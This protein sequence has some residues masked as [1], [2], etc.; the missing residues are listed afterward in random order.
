MAKKKNVWLRRVLGVALAA[1]LVLQPMSTALGTLG[2]V[3]AAQLTE[4]VTSGDFSDSSI[5]EVRTEGASTVN[6]EENKIVF[7]IVDSGADWSN[8]LKYVPGIN[9]KQGQEYVISFTAKSSVSRTIQYGFDSG[10]SGITTTD[11]EAGV[12]TPISYTHTGE[13]NQDGHSYMFYLGAITDGTNPTEAHTVEISNFSVKT[14][15]DTT[16]GDGGGNEGGTEDPSVP[17]TSENLLTNGDFA[18]KQTGWNAFSNNATITW[19]EYS[20]VFE[21]NGYEADWAQSLYQT[22]T[23]EQGEKYKVSFD[24]ESSVPR[25][26]MSDIADRSPREFTS[27]VIPA[28]TKTTLSYETTAPAASS[29]FFIY[30]GGVSEAHTVTISNVSI[31]KATG[32][33]SGETGEGGSGDPGEGGGSGNTPQEPEVPEGADTQDGDPVPAVE[34]NL[35]Q[36]GNFE[37]KGENWDKNNANADVYFNKYRT[38]FQINGE[39]AD[40]GQGLFQFVTL[41]AGPKYKVSFDIETTVERTVTVDINDAGREFTSDVIPANQKTTISYETSDV[42]NGQNKFYIY[43][44]GVSGLGNHK[45]VI[46]NVSIVEC[47]VELPDTENDEAPAALT[48]LKGVNVDDAIALKDGKFTDG[49]NNWETWCVDWMQTW[50]V[51][52]Y[53][54]VENGMSV[55]ITNV[56]DGE[57]NVAWDAQLNQKIDLK[58]DLQYTISFDVHSEK[59]RAFNVVVN[60]LATGEF[61]KTIG[62]QKDETRHVVLNIP[63]QSEDALNKI[64]SIQMGKVTGEVRENTLTFTNMKIEVNGCEAL[65]ERVSDGKF[66]DGFGSFVPGTTAD[67]TIKADEKSVQADILSDTRAEDV[68]LTRGGIDLEAGVTYALS[69]MAGATSGN[70]VITVQLPDGTS[71]PF[72]LTDEATLYTTEFTPANDITAGEIVFLLGGAQDNVCLDTVYLN[73]KGYAEATGI[74]LEQHDIQALT[75]Y[76]APVISEDV[77]AVEGEDVVLTFADEDGAYTQAITGIKVDGVAVDPSKYSVENGTITLDKSLFT[78]SGERQTF[79]I[80][81]EAYWYEKN[82]AIQIVYKEKQWSLTWSDEFNGSSLDTTKWSYQEGTGA[83]YGLDGWGN[84]EQ[85][86]Y[87]RD[88]LSLGDGTMTITATSD[89]RGGKPYSSARIWTMSDDQETPKFAQTYGRFEAKIKMPAGDG[90][91]GLWP[92]FWLLPANSP[93]GGW[94]VSGEIDIME[95]RGRQGDRTDS[96][97]HYGKTYPNEAAEGKTYVWE[98]DDLA[99]TQ[100]HI[101]SVDWTPTYMSFQVD[102]EEFYRATNWYCQGAEEPQKYAF[103]APFDQDFY[104][105]LNLAIGG[106][107][108]GNRNPSESAL[109]AE[110]KVDYVRVYESTTPVGDDYIAPEPELEKDE[111]TADAKTEL[112]DPDFTDVKTVVNDTDDKNVNGWNLLT[113]SQFGGAANISTVDIDGDTF[114]K[115]QITNVGTANYSVQLTQKL[116]L[117]KGHWYTLSFDAKADTAREIIAKIGGDGTNS[118][119]AYHASTTKLTKDVQHYEYIFQMLNDSDPSSRLEMNM[120]LGTA[121]SVYIGNVEFKEVDGY[122]INPDVPKSPLEDGNHIY[123]GDFS[124]GDSSRMAYWHTTGT[125]GKV[126]KSGSEYFFR[127]AGASTLYQTGIELLQSDTYKLTFDAKSASGQEIEVIF[128]DAEGNPYATKTVAVGTTAEQQEVTFTMP[129][130]VTDKNAVVTFR[131]QNADV[132]VDHIV[133]TRE[134]Y[135]NVDFSGLN[136]YPLANGDFELGTIGWSTHQTSLNIV[137]ENGNHIGRVAGVAGGNLWDAL[138]SYG[139]L[140]FVGG[141]D[142]EFSFDVRADKDVTFDISLEDSSYSRYFSKS[143]VAAGTE[144][145]HY[146]YSFK[147]SGDAN[148]A[149]KFLVAGARENYNLDLDNVMIKMKGAPKQSGSFLIN[150]YNKLGEDVVITHSGTAE[151]AEKAVILLDGKTIDADKYTFNGSELVLDASLFTQSREYTISATAEDYS[152]SAPV[153]FRMYPE[154]GDIICNGSMSYGDTA[155]KQYIHGGDSATL[156]F[157]NGYLEARYLHAEGDEWGNPSVPWSIQLNHDIV[158][159]EAGDY[160]ISFVAFSEVERYIMVSIAGQNTK[161]KLTEEPKVH[162]ITVNVANAGSY[163]LQFQMGTV[164]PDIENGYFPAAGFVDFEP[165]NFYVDSISMLPAGTAVVKEP[166]AYVNV[167]E[168]ALPAQVEQESFSPLFEEVFEQQEAGK[169]YTIKLDVQAI[170]TEDVTAEDKAAV[171]KVASEESVAAFYLDINLLAGVDGNYTPI[172]EVG[173]PIRFTLTIPEELRSADRTF[174]V[175]GVHEGEPIKLDDKDL[176]PNTVTVE[177]DKFST[178]VLMYDEEISSGG[179]DSGNN[180]GDSGNGSDSGN[181]GGSNSGDSGNGSNSGNNGGSNSGDSGNGSNGGNNGG[182]NSG[183]SGSGSDSGNNSGNNSSNSGSSNNSNNNSNNSNNSNAGSNQNNSG[184]NDKQT[185]VLVASTKVDATVETTADNAATESIEDTSVSESEE[186]MSATVAPEKEEEETEAVTEDSSQVTEEASPLDSPAEET[187]NGNMWWLL[188]VV[189]LAVVAVVVIVIV[190]KKTGETD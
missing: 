46:S 112:I 86:Y 184:A 95:A 16:S 15:T 47:P 26:V 48:S 188:G 164:D 167:A 176:D 10:R 76:T 99:I 49:L 165:H 172:T 134:T 84:N 75:K 123:N 5:W 33:N 30:L 141:Y 140:E 127:S 175:V 115:V 43:L 142:Y 71:Q 118:W 97:L 23:W 160:D 149:L 73:A 14:S 77:N 31:V 186:E 20:T 103:P 69:F 181:N 129:E 62:L 187:S 72:T 101:Y 82:Q 34:G 182:S 50:N 158:V 63:V 151:W 168:D 83:E 173:T 131:F 121:T 40:W 113:L 59:A 143:N 29:T 21:I 152:N 125:A 35:L 9:V 148:L 147:F 45:V 124:I 85:Q 163:E 139:N 36:N 42:N 96:T 174:Y 122:V 119:S 108:D 178:Y 19:N 179:G 171:Q 6:R 39:A 74:N 28:N 154:N 93:Y 117:Y 146:T 144:W 60:D 44:G 65:A 18:D 138:L 3:E 102:G 177:T 64:F 12:E 2:V 133:L 155:W 32:G 87:T 89:D 81:V 13:Y 114:A 136:C 150:T 180:S 170:Q 22:V 159:N 38:V 116:S 92:A 4:L 27:D 91:Q 80:E 104:I 106:M 135:H 17:R 51:V 79:R 57:G 7:N 25:T 130:N 41:E 162:T 67:A 157:D 190:R 70:R 56:G 37:N 128:S 66:T 145:K 132:E 8:Y 98:E 78:V 68:T 24:I 161:V 110:M 126:I 88:N 166:M 54:P 105:I 109:P 90:C 94:P 169:A 52:R 61:V 1:V 189:V 100:Y 58:K 185:S 153:A 120:G 183:N 111:I 156:N 53:T 137:E 11:L 55:Y 107:Y